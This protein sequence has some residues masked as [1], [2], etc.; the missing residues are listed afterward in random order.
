MTQVHGPAT[1]DEAIAVEAAQRR[2]PARSP[3]SLR[4]ASSRA[5]VLMV[6]AAIGI[7]AVLGGAAAFLV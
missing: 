4:R 3:L 5:R 1:A 6:V 2:P 7:T